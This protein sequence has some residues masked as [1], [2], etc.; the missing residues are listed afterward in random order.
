MP[1]Q[2]L[3]TVTK[4]ANAHARR[5][6]VRSQ[7]L[8]STTSLPVETGGKLGEL[9]PTSALKNVGKTK[10]APPAK[11]PA[12]E[13]NVIFSP[14]EGAV[15]MQN[16]SP[17]ER[18]PIELDETLP[19]RSPQVREEGTLAL[20][21]AA[22]P[23]NQLIV[24][25]MLPVLNAQLQREEKYSPNLA[26]G[27]IAAQGTAKFTWKLALTVLLKL[28]LSGEEDLHIDD[29]WTLALRN[30]KEA[31]LFASGT[32]FIS[33]RWLSLELAWSDYLSSYVPKARSKHLNG[34]AAARPTA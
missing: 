15:Q 34:I 11:I 8:A 3:L 33:E 6:D 18:L 7:S 24:M 21:W 17:V 28:A 20:R 30:M 25:M 9:L 14:P 26:Q 19:Y 2:Q 32:Y 13:H 27:T 22:P 16:G 23:G 29:D 5:G 10:S 4:D 31:I 1:L 12:D